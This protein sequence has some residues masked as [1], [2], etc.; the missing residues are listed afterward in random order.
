M[1]VLENSFGSHEEIA[2]EAKREAEV[3]KRIGELRKEGFWSARRL[4]KVQEMSRN[5]AHWDYLLEEM[6]WLATDFAQ[7]R[8]WKRGVAKKLSRAVLKHHQELKSK[9]VKAEKEET[10]RLRR[11]ASS[12]AREVKQFWA[13]VEKVPFSCVM[14]VLFVGN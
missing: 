4:P 2:V 7:E 9:E 3:L 1:S 12:I 8:R 13:N 11:I 6:Q 14:F 5:K 10:V